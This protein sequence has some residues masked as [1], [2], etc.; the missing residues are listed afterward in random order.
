MKSR[1]NEYIFLQLVGTYRAVLKECGKGKR[2]FWLKCFITL[3]TLVFHGAG[4]G[5][6]CETPKGK[7]W[8]HWAAYS[9]KKALLKTSVTKCVCEI[10]Y[11]SEMNTDFRGFWRWGFLKWS[12]ILHWNIEYIFVRDSLNTLWRSNIGLTQGRSMT[13]YN[14]EVWPLGGWQA[15]SN[16][17]LRRC[18]YFVTW[19][20]D[21]HQTELVKILSVRL[22]W[23]WI[24]YL[25]S[26]QSVEPLDRF[27]VW[28]EAVHPVHIQHDLTESWRG[29]RRRSA[30]MKQVKT[31]II[32]S[33]QTFV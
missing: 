1:D 12:N 16:A 20:D 21:R 24:Y 30:L 19:L 27:T 11:F 31:V 26:N 28:Y 33:T 6:L 10:F 22:W 8:S 25:G 29:R 9:F 2:Y 4:L 18:D 5:S 7:W 17:F 23:T 32:W 15:Q 3:R 13:T 14:D